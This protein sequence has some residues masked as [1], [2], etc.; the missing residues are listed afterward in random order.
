MVGE[1]PPPVYAHEHSAEIKLGLLEQLD[2]HAGSPAVAVTTVLVKVAQ[3]GDAVATWLLMNDAQ[4]L[5]LA[6]R[7]PKTPGARTRSA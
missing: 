3:N 4:E 1:D 7:Q 5:E 6:L 2:A